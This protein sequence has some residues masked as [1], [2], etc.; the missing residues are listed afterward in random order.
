MFMNSRK[1]HEQ[2]HSH[3]NLQKRIISNKNFTYRNV[4]FL[5]K[6][7]FFKKRG[8]ILDVGC[9]VGT[10]DFYLS[11]QGYVISGIDISKKAIVAARRNARFFDLKNI[12]FY[13]GDINNFKFKSKFD[14]ILCSEII[15]HVLDDKRMLIDLCRN[16]KKD[17][18]ILLTTPLETAPLYKLSLTKSFDIRVG[19]QRRYT[20]A[21][22]KKIANESGLKIIEVYYQDGVFRNIFF[23]FPIFNQ[24]VR[25]ANRFS[26]VSDVL[27]IIDNISLK[28]FGPTDIAVVI[29]KK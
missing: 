6:N 1:I 5:L 24:V 15:E 17:G 28:I 29:K 18:I 8:K 11:K 22:L 9:G 13:L 10:I 14:L 12:K 25:V 3:T 2:Y 19:H 23:V 4:T 16:L 21:K 20:L 26:Y 27:T 7:T